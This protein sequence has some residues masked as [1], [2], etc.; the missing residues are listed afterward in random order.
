MMLLFASYA[1]AFM[2]LIAA[3]DAPF[4]PSCH[5][6][7]ARFSPLRVDDA[8]IDDAAA[9]AAALI[10]RYAAV[11][12]MI[13]RFRRHYDAF[14]HYHFAVLMLTFALPPMLRHTPT[15]FSRH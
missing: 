13:F 9:A 12:A 1:D 5:A 11:F 4:S 15:L 6:S 10:Y 2:I 3:A 7:M 14:F 8:A